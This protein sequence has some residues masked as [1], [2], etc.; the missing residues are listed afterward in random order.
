MYLLYIHPK[1]KKKKKKER[2]TDRQKENQTKEN[3]TK[4]KNQEQD[5]GLTEG[6]DGS[7][8]SCS[9]TFRAPLR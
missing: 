6:K 2:Q 1:K 8:P 3:Q 7:L 5:H 4:Q 9:L